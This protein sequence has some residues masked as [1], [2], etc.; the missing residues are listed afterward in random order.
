[1]LAEAEAEEQMAGS[2]DASPSGEG[3]R[4]DD[5]SHNGSSSAFPAVQGHRVG[6][7]GLAVLR[8]REIPQDQDL[9][10]PSR[11]SEI[12]DDLPTYDQ[13]TTGADDD[14][15][16][17]ETVSMGPTS[18]I[19]NREPGWGWGN[20]AM[21]GIAGHNSSDVDAES[22]R[23]EGI[24][25]TSSLGDVSESFIHSEDVGDY[26]QRSMR[27]SAPAPDVPAV[28]IE[29]AN[30]DDDDLPVAE[31]RADDNTGEMQFQREIN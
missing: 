12:H 23:G 5:S 1:M 10:N 17:D 25:R 15:L 31:L 13:A 8:N 3:R 30:N 28:S 21:E 19:W 2:R 7:G 18:D 27:E 29:P 4:L 6:D 26:Q 22:T 9:G 11:M 20:L 16:L 14:M 24:S